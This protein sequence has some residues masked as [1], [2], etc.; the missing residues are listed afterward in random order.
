MHYFQVLCAFGVIIVAVVAFWEAWRLTAPSQQ[1]EAPRRPN[2]QPVTHIA[3][4]V[5][6]VAQKVSHYQIIKNCAKSY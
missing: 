1:D 5:Y 2:V 6:R 3:E 4:C